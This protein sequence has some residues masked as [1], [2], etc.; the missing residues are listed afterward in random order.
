MPLVGAIDDLAVGSADDLGSVSVARL[1]AAH[2]VLLDLGVD[3]TLGDSPGGYLDVLI[4]VRRLGLQEVVRA[5]R[6]AAGL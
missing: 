4:L 6:C 1:S 3:E 5:E 2:A